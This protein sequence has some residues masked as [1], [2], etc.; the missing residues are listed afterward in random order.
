M[1]W[2]S[3]LFLAF[4]LAVAA[5]AGPGQAQEVEDEPV[6]TVEVFYLTNRDAGSGR[7]E[8]SAY[9]GARGEPQF[10]RCRAAFTPIPI[11]NSVGSEVPFYFPR[12]TTDIRPAETLDADRF[13]E[14]LADAVAGTSSQSVVVFVHGY[15]YGFERT[16]RMAAE[17]QRSLDGDAVVVMFSWPSNGLPTDYVSDLADIEWSVPLLSEL[18]DRL[19]GRLGAEGVQVLAHSRPARRSSSS[20]NSGTLH[21]MSARSLT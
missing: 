8:A 15:N 12:E 4:T 17:M 14:S 20:D 16:C 5:V 10:G 11:L 6:R 9:G 1:P 13:L 19:A 18:L 2:S 7:S 3:A 21:S